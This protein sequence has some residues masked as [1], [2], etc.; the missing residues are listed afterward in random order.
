MRKLL[1]L[2]FSLGFVAATAHAEDEIKFYGVVDAGVGYVNHSLNAD[3]NLMGTINPLVSTKATTDV[4]AM[5][6]GGIS[7]SRVGVKGSEDLEGGMKFL[8]QLETGFNLPTGTINN[9]ELAVAS[10]PANATSANANSSLGGQLFNRQAWLAMSGEYG[11]LTLG[12]SYNFIYDVL[13]AY[14]PVKYAQLF[15]PISFSGGLGGGAGVSEDTRVDDNIKWTAKFDKINV[16]L[17]YKVGGIA[18]GNANAGQQINIGYE[19]E[20]FGVQLL[21]EQHSDSLKVGNQATAAA[22]TALPCAATA[23]QVSATAYNTTDTI[24]AAKYKFGE[25]G[26][27][28][29]G[30]EKYALS[31]PSNP[32]LDTAIS[33][34]YGFSAT[35]SANNSDNQN[36]S[37]YFAG[38]NFNFSEKTD[39]SI[40]WYSVNLDG[41]NKYNAA[42]VAT[43]VNGG[44]QT[45][46]SFLLDH[47]YTKTTDSYLGILYASLGGGGLYSTVANPTNATYGLGL[48]HKF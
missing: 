44:T 21:W 35:I 40:G 29:A 38:G 3:P 10:N 1:A 36:V 9:N 19:D 4:V 27:V 22:C 6:N 5:F 23:T 26:S 41:Y 33:N 17:A 2:I 37:I 7:D 43:W 48:R 12:R 34:L 13:S 42:G 11:T 28:K 24:L 31:N 25:A 8:Y 47:N 16:G 30:Y 39:V 46:Y 15:S 20:S 45:Y 14:D 18:G 32:T